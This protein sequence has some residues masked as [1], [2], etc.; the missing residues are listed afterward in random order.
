MVSSTGARTLQRNLRVH[1]EDYGVTSWC[2][3]NVAKGKGINSE[4]ME[5][6][7][8]E[9]F[10]AKGVG[11]LT[12]KS[13][14]QANFWIDAKHTEQ[15]SLQTSAHDSIGL[16]GSTLVVQALMAQ[17]YKSMKEDFVSNLSGGSIGEINQVTAVAPVSAICLNSVPRTNFNGWQ[18][19]LICYG[20]PFRL[21]KVSSRTRA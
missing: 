14:A 8:I 6:L 15:H 3:V 21:G 7:L 9:S 13:R 2:K 11:E 19:L 4:V 10:E 1:D 18:R 5:S 12:F 20:L 17:S 16:P